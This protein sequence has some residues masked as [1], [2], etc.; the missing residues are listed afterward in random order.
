MEDRQIDKW[1][2]VAANNDSILAG[3]LQSDA[4]DLFAMPTTISLVDKLTAAIEVVNRNLF[5]LFLNRS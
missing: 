3:G 1:P 4:M 2:A 5:M